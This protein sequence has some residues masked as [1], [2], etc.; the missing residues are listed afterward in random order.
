MKVGRALLSV[1]DKACIVDLGRGLTEAGVEIVSSGG[2]AAALAEAG[3]P[4]TPVAEVT[5][6]P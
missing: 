5:G 2:T 3:I 4:V 6:A 1:S